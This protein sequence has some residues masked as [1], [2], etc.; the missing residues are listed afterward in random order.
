MDTNQIIIGIFAIVGVIIVAIIIYYLI[1]RFWQHIQKPKLDWP[2]DDYM[3][4]VGAQCPDYWN[5]DSRQGNT[6]ICRNKFHLPVVK[7]DRPGCQDVNCNDDTAV[8]PYITNWPLHR[9]NRRIMTRC[10]WR[11]CCGYDNATPASWVG[12]DQYC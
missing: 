10:K 8:F 11:N 2:P 6:V 1:V 7:S 5:I 12:L 3:K 4:Y 9:N